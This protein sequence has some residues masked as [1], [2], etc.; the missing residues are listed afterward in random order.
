[1]FL[2]RTGPARRTDEEGDS[3]KK[4]ASD[5]LLSKRD[6]LLSKRI[7]WWANRRTTRFTALGRFPGHLVCLAAIALATLSAHAAASELPAGESVQSPSDWR[8]DFLTPSERIAYA[9]DDPLDWV[10]EPSE[11]LADFFRGATPESLEPYMES[12]QLLQQAA[13]YSDDA[14]LIAFVIEHGF[15]P[16]EAFGPGI[17]AYPQDLSPE[18][19]REGPLHFAAK[20]NPNPRIVDALVKGGANVHAPGGSV[21]STPLHHA[22]GYNNA[23]VVSA[24]IQNGARV[25]DVNGRIDSSWNRAANINGNTALHAA[26]HKRRRLDH[27]RACRRGGRCAAKELEWHD[28]AAL[29]RPR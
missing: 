25:G 18:P 5:G 23:A 19:A 28:A 13:R 24:L 4:A 3:G 9:L 1:M 12:E 26:A 8:E 22:A 29:R 14:A 17:P 27:R 15:D 2:R 20:Y 21:L 7:V 6:G 10:W 11:I 16:N